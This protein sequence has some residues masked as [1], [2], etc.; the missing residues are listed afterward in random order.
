MELDILV[1]VAHPDDAEICCGGTILNQLQK[2]NTVGI[3]DLTQGELGTRGNA[4]LRLKEAQDAAKVLGVTIRENMGFADGFFKNDECH[5]LELIKKIRQYRPKV[6]ITNP[7][8]ERHPDHYRAAKLV[9]EACFYS[10]LAK[11]NT[12]LNGEQQEAWRPGT[13]HYFLQ[14]THLEPDFIVDI[15]AHLDKKF[16]AVRAF[17]SQFYD[18]KS[19]EPQTF[20]TQEKFMEQLKATN[21]AFGFRGGFY[22]GEGFVTENKIGITDIFHIQ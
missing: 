17:K 16:E 10:G 15:S 2:G 20:L 5:R 4:N 6:V 9:K 3:I 12:R 11:I 8:A 21:I 18:S 19:E 13:L 7:P 22:A 14:F 1:I